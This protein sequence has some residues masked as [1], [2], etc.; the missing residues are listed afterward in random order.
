M[1]RIAIAFLTVLWLAPTAPAQESLKA[2]DLARIKAATAFIKVGTPRSGAVATGSGFLVKAEGDSAWLVTNHH[3]VDLHEDGDT[4]KMM[5]TPI[6]VVFESGTEKERSFKATI[7][8]HDPTRDL[9][10]LKIDG[11]KGMPA[12]I[13]IDDKI[14]LRETMQVYICGFPFGGRLAIGTKNPEIS[15]GDA[16]VSSL[17]REVAGGPI[18]KVQLNGALN[19]GNSGG[20]VVAANG[21]LVGV[22]VTTVRNAGIGYAV[23]FHEVTSM[24]GGRL[25]TISLVPKNDNDDLSK[26]I[27]AILRSR[28]I[29][30]FKRVKSVAAHVLPGS[31]E[32]PK[33]A[34]NAPPGAIPG[35]MKVPMTIVDGVATADVTVPANAKKSLIVQLEIQYDGGKAFTNAFVVTA[36]PDRSGMPG[37]V[38]PRNNPYGPRRTPEGHLKLASGTVLPFPSVPAKFPTASNSESVSLMNASPEL[39]VGKAVRMDALSTCIVNPV[40]RGEFELAVETDSDNAPTELRVVLPKDLALQIADL[41]IPELLPIV[42]QIK[43]PIRVIGTVTKPAGREKRHTLTAQSVEFLDEDGKSVTAFKPAVEPPAGKPTLATVNRFPEKYVGQTLTVTAYVK[44]TRHA[45][46]TGMDIGTENMAI[47]LNLENYTSRNLAGQVE[48]DIAKADL[49]ARANLTIEVKAIH[50]KSNKGVIGI[51]QVEVLSDDN[52]PMKTLKTSANVEY[53]VIPPPPKAPTPKV[54]EAA[55]PDAP[56]VAEKAVTPAAEGGNNAVLFVAIGVS[57]VLL[58]VGGFLLFTAL[59][60]TK[61]DGED[62][63]AGE[64]AEAEKPETK[65]RSYVPKAT[66]PEPEIKPAKTKPASPNPKSN[67]HDNPFANFS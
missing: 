36:G 40:D 37:G 26:E 12:P 31:A 13:E 2:E 21:K 53:P 10:T 5:T 35:A 41:G 33:A 38:E 8:A 19:P 11:A 4:A 1:P 14:E 48:S 17:R 58:V 46:G 3:V 7:V 57:A 50:G 29:D 45:G 43:Y 22:A 66:K 52:K 62:R 39:F 6:E 30:P 51:R 44:G 47:P 65:K 60:K 64:K 59:R 56:K 9:A 20:P 63:D 25:G 67:G 61:S 49:P 24:L 18:A 27:A 54:V 34:P 42:A 23:P 16:K 28:V 55:N 32:M 15:I